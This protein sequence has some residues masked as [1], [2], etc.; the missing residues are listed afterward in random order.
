VEHLE[1]LG[2]QHTAGSACP[3]SHPSCSINTFNW[4]TST[5]VSD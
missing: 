3:S 1:K 4:T 5:S 2:E